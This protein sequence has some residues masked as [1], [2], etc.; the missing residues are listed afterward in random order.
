MAKKFGGG[1]G[2]SSMV[3]Y[4]VAFII[5]IAIGAAIF[6]T[7]RERFVSAEPSI[8]FYMRTGCGWCEKMKPELAKF[9]E[10]VAAEKVGVN[11]VESIDDSAAADAAGV[12]GFPT[13][14]LTDGKQPKLEFSGERTA[15]GLLEF[16]K[17]NI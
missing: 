1:T 16:V 11:V 8:T 17:K 6:S 2:P 10:L 5:L 9:K 12:K 7:V 15:T 3:F 4:A 14:I 13:I